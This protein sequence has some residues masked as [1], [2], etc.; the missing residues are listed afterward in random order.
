MISNSVLHEQ[1]KHNDKGGMGITTNEVMTHAHLYA[2]KNDEK[3]SEKIEKQ[4]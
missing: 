4:K 2:F 3:I 1:K